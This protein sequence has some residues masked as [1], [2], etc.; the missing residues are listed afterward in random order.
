[1]EI[2]NDKD[3]TSVEQKLGDIGERLKSTAPVD[4]VFPKFVA[5]EGRVHIVV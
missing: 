3:E 4:R 5:P 2:A 1:M